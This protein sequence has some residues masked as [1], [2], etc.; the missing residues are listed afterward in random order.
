MRRNSTKEEIEVVFLD[1]DKRAIEGKLKD[2][3]AKT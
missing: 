1:I 2:I 3:G